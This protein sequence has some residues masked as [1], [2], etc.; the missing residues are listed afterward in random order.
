MKSCLFFDKVWYV[1]HILD[2]TSPLLKDHVKVHIKKNGGD[3]WPDE[4]DSYE[5][6]QD[7]I[8]DFQLITVQLQ[9][10]SQVTASPVYAEMEYNIKD[11]YIGWQFTG[12]LY[13]T[14]DIYGK[15]KIVVD[16]SI[17]HDITPQRGGRHQPIHD[18]V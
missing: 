6:I 7:S 12:L 14:K 4:L 9:G 13:H 3:T 5:S 1:R 15:H 2:E 17:M 16:N 11:I 10:M 18:D 8:I